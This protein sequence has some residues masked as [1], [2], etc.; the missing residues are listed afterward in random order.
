MRIFLPTVRILKCSYTT[1]QPLDLYL[2][3][4]LEIDAPI[5]PT[6][7]DPLAYHHLIRN[8][9]VAINHCRKSKFKYEESH[10]AMGEVC[11]HIVY[12]L[13][14]YGLLYRPSSEHKQF[15]FSPTV[16]PQTS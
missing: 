5:E 15:F 6:D 3:E 9:Y 8:T 10:V 2:L 4:V 1:V 12:F 16:R 11:M 14:T 13:I 7:A